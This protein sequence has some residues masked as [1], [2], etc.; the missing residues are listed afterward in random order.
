M[1]PTA[2]F[3][4]SILNNISNITYFEG[5]D[6]DEFTCISGDCISSSYKCDG[7]EDCSD[8]DDEEG[9]PGNLIL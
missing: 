2:T 8:G 4:V 7:D 1:R 6:A 3:H 5:C 9:C